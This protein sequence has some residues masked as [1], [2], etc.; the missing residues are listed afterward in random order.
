MIN[1]E[2]WR[3][4][5]YP[6]GFLANAVFLGRFLVQWL[7]SEKAQKSVVPP[8]F[9]KLSLIGNLLL[10]LHSLIQVQYHICLVQACNAVISWRN[11]N[12][13]QSSR[14]PVSLK[15]VCLLLGGVAA[16]VSAAFALQ[17]WLFMHEGDW[18]RVPNT[19]WQSPT[20]STSLFWHLLGAL[21]YGLFCSRFWIQWWMAE[22]SQT[23]QLLPSFWWLS[24]IGALLSIVY[25]FHIGDLVNLLGP[26][27]GLI[28]Y[29]RN[30]VLLYKSKTAAQS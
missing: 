21:A 9:W 2:E 27:V 23:S 6:F 26:L 1:F 17:D 4:F 16:L 25:F 12:L 15:V 5:L 20:I 30:L 19:P 28:P 22:Q 11:L 29:T 24:L 8:I 10:T 3:T 13:M 7:Q 14:P 18:F